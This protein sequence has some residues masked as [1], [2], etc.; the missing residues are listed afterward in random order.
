MIIHLIIQKFHRSRRHYAM[1]G[2][3]PVAEEYTRCKAQDVN[4]DHSYTLSYISGKDANGYFIR[5]NRMDEIVKHV[6][7]TDGQELC[8]VCWAK[9]LKETGY[10]A[11]YEAWCQKERDAGDAKRQ[12][13]RDAK[14]N[15]QPAPDGRVAV[16]GKVF[17]IKEGENDFGH[18]RKMMVRITSEDHRGST[19]YVSA[20]TLHHN[21]Q[22]FLEVNVDDIIEFKATFE[23]QEDTTFAFGKR[24]TVV[25][26]SPHYE[27]NAK[28]VKVGRGNMMELAVA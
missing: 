19:V 3:N 9:A 26:W 14:A 16:T 1:H 21:G 24:P 5:Q 20:P 15:A 13:I 10:T 11:M 28:Y 7:M 18:W 17:K 6:E 25:S 12:E 23:R 27:E 8:M 2:P 4:R 22:D